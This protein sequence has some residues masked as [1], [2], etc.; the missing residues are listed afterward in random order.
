M[1]QTGT[2]VPESVRVE[3]TPYWRGWQL[4]NSADGDLLDRDLRSAG[5][6]F[7]FL[8][9]TVQAMV[10]GHRGEKAVRKSAEASADESEVVEVQLRGNNGHSE[11]VSGASLRAR[12]GALATDAEKLDHAVAGG[13]KSGRGCCLGHGVAFRW[14]RSK[15]R[16]RESSANA[17]A[18]ST[19]CNRSGLKI[20]M[21]NIYIGNLDYTTTEEQLRTLFLA[22]GTVETV[23]V[24]RDRDTGQPRGFAFLEMTN[25]QEADKAIHALNGVVLGDRTLTVNEARS[26]PAGSHGDDSQ[27]RQHRL[28]RF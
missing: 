7:F 6:N 23:T 13:K 18:E 4:I 22:H 8:A 16:L 5:W 9:D 21:K 25:D 14:H 19:P 28:N 20:T 17:S 11:A 12:V 26:K 2:F 1:M 3:A 27:K 10:W 24:V 15:G